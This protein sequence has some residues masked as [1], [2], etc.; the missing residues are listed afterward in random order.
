MKKLLLLLCLPVALTAQTFTDTLS[1][2][3]PLNPTAY[4]NGDIVCSKVD[5]SILRFSRLAVG[6]NGGFITGAYIS[7]DTASTA[8]SFRLWLFNDSTGFAKIGDNAAW[9]APAAMIRANLLGFIDFNL[10]SAGLGAGSN[11][12]A[13]YQTNLN[14]PLINVK[15]AGVFGILTATAAYTPKYNGRITLRMVAYKP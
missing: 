7:V 9:V 11:G 5:S 1:F 12:S 15:G 3:R 2:W 6:A 8:G 14:I 10:T 13:D 4:A